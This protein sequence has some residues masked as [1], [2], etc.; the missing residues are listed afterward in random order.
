MNKEYMQVCTYYA[1]EGKP[2]HGCGI[3]NHKEG[4]FANINAACF[5]YPK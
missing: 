1:T 2:A 5:L 4:P 3:R